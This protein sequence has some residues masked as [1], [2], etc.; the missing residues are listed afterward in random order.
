MP[1]Q[2]PSTL[3]EVPEDLQGITLSQEQL[4]N[5]SLVRATAKRI[6]ERFSDETSFNT[7]TD[8]RNCLSGAQNEID[9]TESIIHDK[10]P[11]SGWRS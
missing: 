9:A 3:I 6:S 2:P 7:T 4:K 11:H 1:E 8:L 10:P 5:I